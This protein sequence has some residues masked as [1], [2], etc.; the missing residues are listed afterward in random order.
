MY[1]Y[2]IQNTDDRSIVTIPFKT[3]EYIN[4]GKLILALL[5]KN[6]EL[7]NIMLQYGHLVCQANDIVAIKNNLR[8]IT[9]DIF[10]LYHNIKPSV[11]TPEQAVEKI[12]NLSEQI[13]FTENNS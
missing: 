12:I 13:P 11:F 3:Y 2:L 10:S 9:G 6:K 7:E 8:R 4:T 5:Y 1:Y